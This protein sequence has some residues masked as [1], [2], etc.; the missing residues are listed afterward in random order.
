M[1]GVQSTGSN[2]HTTRLYSIYPL[3]RI[4]YGLAESL[5]LLAR[6]MPQVL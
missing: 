3:E 1:T 2:Q 6:I 4:V 5:N